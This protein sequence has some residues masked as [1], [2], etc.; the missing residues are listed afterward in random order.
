MFGEFVCTLISWAGLLLLGGFARGELRNGRS[1]LAFML[2]PRLGW[3]L[4]GGRLT[5]GGIR[6]NGTAFF[7]WHLGFSLVEASVH[8]RSIDTYLL[9]WTSR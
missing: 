3:D 6:H 7:G 2:K 9:M 1:V 4:T 8:H 5:R